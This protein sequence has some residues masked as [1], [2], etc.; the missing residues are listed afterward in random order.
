M[1]TGYFLYA[2][3][4]SWRR[5][6]NVY[7]Q[8]WLYSVLI[9]TGFAVLHHVVSSRILDR[10]FGKDQIL[11]TVLGTFLPFSYRSYWFISAYIV[12][13]LFSPFLNIFVHNARMREQRN[14]IFLLF[15]MHILLLAFLKNYYWN[16]VILAITSYL[17]GANLSEQV[18]DESWKKHHKD[19]ENR[20]FA[21]VAGVASLATLAFYAVILLPLPIIKVFQWDQLV[22]NGD[23]VLSLITGYC[24][25]ALALTL[26]EEWGRSMQ[27][28]ILPIASA[29]IGVYLLHENLFGFRIFWHEIFQNPIA[30]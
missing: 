27:R 13:L 10:L 8:M 4:F 3:A 7:V 9:F 25:F 5:I 20:K 6:G 28:I 16:N 1:I 23:M 14:L 11:T 2:C 24:L 30:R 12:L 29:T 15:S 17:M 22:H 18:I 26:P 21:I 19:K